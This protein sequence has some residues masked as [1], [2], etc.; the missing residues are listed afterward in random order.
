MTVSDQELEQIKDIIYEHCDRAFENLNPEY[1]E[2][3]TMVVLGVVVDNIIAEL[4]K[5]KESQ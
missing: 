4:E 5:M 3:G 1:F 2:H